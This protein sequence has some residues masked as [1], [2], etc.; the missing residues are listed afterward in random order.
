MIR[1]DAGS[2][3]INE[4]SSLLIILTI[5]SLSFFAISMKRYIE[6]NNK[7]HKKSLASYTNNNLKFSTLIGLLSSIFFYFL[8]I[9]IVNQNLFIT[10]PLVLFFLFRYY[11]TYKNKNKLSPID[12]VLKDAFLLIFAFTYFITLLLIMY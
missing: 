2:T 3:I 11:F 8:Y 9:L 5:F 10:F 1:V 6:F 12:I 7:I 4:Q